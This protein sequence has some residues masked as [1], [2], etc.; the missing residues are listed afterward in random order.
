MIEQSE[1]RLLSIANIYKSLFASILSKDEGIDAEQLT[2][3][4]L[5]ALGHTSMRRRWPL[6]SFALEK[7][8]RD[9]G[10]YE[11]AK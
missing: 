10:R 2:Q 11:I 1:S 5:N 6:I 7:I 3:A 9:L 8:S 4:A